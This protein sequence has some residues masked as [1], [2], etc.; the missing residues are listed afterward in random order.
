MRRL[1]WT[2]YDCESNLQTWNRTDGWKDRTVV[3]ERS[4][5]SFVRRIASRSKARRGEKGSILCAKGGNPLARCRTRLSSVR[6]S[7]TSCDSVGRLETARKSTMEVHA[8]HPHLTINRSLGCARKDARCSMNDVQ[9]V[10]A[11]HDDACGRKCTAEI[12]FLEVQDHHFPA[13]FAE[14]LRGERSER[15][16]ASEKVMVYWMWKGFYIAQ[17]ALVRFKRLIRAAWARWHV[18]LEWVPVT[19]AVYC[20]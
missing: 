16:K 6:A 5:P 19:S 7:D 1:R 4:S 14:Q 10:H 3:A 18:W 9:A 13:M 2:S 17:A 15:A 20:H 12:V 11:L 8:S